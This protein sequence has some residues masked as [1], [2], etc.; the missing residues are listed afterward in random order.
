MTTLQ[1][2][3]SLVFTLIER[4]VFVQNIHNNG[5]AVQQMS[6]VSVDYSGHD[7]FSVDCV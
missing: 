2:L 3:F 4:M 6:K 7:Q 5:S 1:C